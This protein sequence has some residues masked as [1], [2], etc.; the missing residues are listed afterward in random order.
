MR[1]ESSDLRDIE[2]NMNEAALKRASSTLTVED[3]LNES[4]ITH[5]FDILKYI[6][7]SVNNSNDNN[8]KDNNNIPMF[9]EPDIIDPF[10]VN[11]LHFINI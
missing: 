1:R 11:I 9:N 7:K 2:E 4:N 10:L 8:N 3:F 6:N 5:E